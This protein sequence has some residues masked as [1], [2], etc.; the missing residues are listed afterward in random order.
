ML[1]ENTRV[2]TGELW[3]GGLCPGKQRDGEKWWGS[4]GHL[5]SL[6]ASLLLKE[7]AVVRGESESLILLP[8]S[9]ENNDSSNSKA[10]KILVIVTG[11]SWL[12]G[13]LVGFLRFCSKC[14][15]LPNIFNSFTR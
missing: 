12:W 3:L 8:D 14:S 13:F 4:K 5:S 7:G 1:L 11:S 6:C 2:V 10:R 15:Q 9:T